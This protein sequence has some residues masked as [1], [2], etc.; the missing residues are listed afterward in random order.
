[1]IGGPEDPVGNTYTIE[2]PLLEEAF[3]DIDGTQ[4]YRKTIITATIP[5]QT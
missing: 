3:T 4:Y 2:T 1:L 5:A